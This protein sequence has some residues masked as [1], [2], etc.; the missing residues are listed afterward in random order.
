MRSPLLAPFAVLA[1]LAIVAAP[2]LAHTG[3]EHTMLE[4]FG[5]GFAH[6]FGG[7]DHLLAMIAVGVWAAQ[8]GGRAVWFVPLAFVG[9]MAAGGIAGFLGIGIGGTETVIVASVLV[10]GAV[11]AAAA[12]PPLWIAMPLVGAFALFHGLAHGAELPEAADKIGYA[13]GFIAATAILHAA[14]VA[15]AVALRK[16]APS[17]ALRTAG[18]AQIA[19][20]VL[21]AAGVI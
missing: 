18:A 8:I 2:A 20:G 6:P 19:A 16:G 1:A 3:H 14:G 5:A 13:A 7:V 12:K 21:L 9:T 4:G 11:I 10:L 17:F 15:L